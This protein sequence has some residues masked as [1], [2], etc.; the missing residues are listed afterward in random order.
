MEPE[1]ATNPDSIQRLLASGANPLL[2]PT[3][4]SNP[5]AGSQGSEYL[6]GLSEHDAFAA[7]IDAYRLRVE[8]KYVFRQNSSGLYAGEDPMPEFKRFL[9]LAEKGKNVLPVRW[10][11][12]KRR[13]CE[14]QANDKKEWSCVY[15]AAEERD[16]I[17][18]YKND[19]MPVKL[20]MLAE[21]VYGSNIV[22]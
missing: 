15:F 18:H 8:D 14:R 1:A 12:K 19:S 11:K 3:T 16:I 21:R 7:I 20:R 22:G 2:D 13:A 6:S 9:N 17:E 10:D 4:S 5:S